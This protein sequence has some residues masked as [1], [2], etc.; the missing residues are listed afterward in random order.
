MTEDPSILLC[1]VSTNK[2]SDPV[3]CA[4]R[5]LGLDPGL[6]G[7]V[8]SSMRADLI[9]L[10]DAWEQAYSLETLS[11]RRTDLRRFIAW[12]A[13]RDIAPF[14]GKDTL[15]DTISDH[16]L[17]LSHEMKSASLKRAGSAL[18]A[19]ARGLDIDGPGMEERQR[20]VLRACNREARDRRTAR[21][22]EP[23]RLTFEQIRAVEDAIGKSDVS[24][25]K[26]LRD[27]AIWKIMAE[28]M[29]RRSELVGFR[30]IDW[31]PKDSCLI[32]A[33]AKADQAGEGHAFTLS[34][35][36]SSALKTWLA[37]SELDQ[38]KGIDLCAEIPLFIAVRREGCLRIGPDGDFHPMTG[39]SV[40]RLMKDYAEK[41]DMPGV[42]G[43]TLRRSMA[44]ILCNAGIDEDDVVEAGRWRSR[45]MMRAYAGL[46]SLR[47]SVHNLLFAT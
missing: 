32:I 5:K 6:C 13:A 7:S 17:D 11:S 31:N 9:R 35:E 16:F 43:H 44:R 10:P 20:L 25:L 36:T 30:L 1:E 8:C 42:S 46:A 47:K 28:L 26:R 19:L 39:R 38:I 4:L 12:C 27:V 21:T 24:N 45:K 33:H 15:G 22:P 23:V 29:L 37:V 18:I 34:D 40:A 41:A 2:L 3:S 14:E